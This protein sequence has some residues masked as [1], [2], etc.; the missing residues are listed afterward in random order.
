MRCESY[1]DLKTTGLSTFPLLHSVCGFGD[2]VKI[3]CFRV[4]GANTITSLVSHLN[5]A[6]QPP[7]GQGGTT[8]GQ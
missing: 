5:G 2:E 4:F 7:F 1:L 8:S 6:D 3:A